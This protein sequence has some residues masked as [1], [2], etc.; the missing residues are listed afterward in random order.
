MKRI[1]FVLAVAVLAALPK[2]SAQSK[3]DPDSF[4]KEAKMEFGVQG[5]LKGS[6]D[7][8]PTLT[9]SYASFRPNGFGWRAGVQYMPLYMETDNFLAFPISVAWRTRSLSNKERVQNAAASA[10]FTLMDWF[11]DWVWGW[12]DAD[13]L[14]PRMLAAVAFGLFSR[15]EFSLGITPG[16][17]MGDENL[18]ESSDFPTSSQLQYERSGVHKGS[19]AYL[20]LDAAYTM[21]WRIWRFN[22]NLT[23]GFHYNVIRTF[24]DYSCRQYVSYPTEVSSKPIRWMFS[25][26]G[27]VSWMF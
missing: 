1:T 3:I 18:Y 20:T 11:W 25:V 24:R 14:L 8:E 27:G 7:M 15:G 12:E 4:L 2:A 5:P 21:S 10:G 6:Y 13:D 22:L 23:P 17:V 19:S 16:L 26:N 9:F